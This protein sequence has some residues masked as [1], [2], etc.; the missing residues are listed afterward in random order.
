MCN[1]GVMPR[2][3]HRFD[4]FVMNQMWKTGGGDYEKNMHKNYTKVYPKRLGF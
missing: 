2:N 4:W 1:V 3:Y